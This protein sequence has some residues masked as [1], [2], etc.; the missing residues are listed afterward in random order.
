LGLPMTMNTAAVAAAAA[1][2]LA[3]FVARE[4]SR[5]V[6]RRYEY[7]WE[8]FAV[9]GPG[10]RQMLHIR[11]SEILSLKPL[12]LMERLSGFGAFKQLS[13]S[14]FGPKVVIRS[15]IAHAKPVIISWEGQAIAG[16]TPPG[17]KLRRKG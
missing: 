17:L 12:G 7:R 1:A 8:T 16:L 2:L 9:R 11:Q 5:R 4:I 14:S 3:L 6:R 10:G 13:R 15:T